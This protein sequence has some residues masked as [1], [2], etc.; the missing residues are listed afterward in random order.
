M[1]V[2]ANMSAQVNR[3]PIQPPKV[4]FMRFTHYTAT[5]L[6]NRRAQFKCT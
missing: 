2:Q 1:G 6:A 5:G 4:A 3:Y